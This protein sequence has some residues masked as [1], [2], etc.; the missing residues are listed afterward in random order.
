[1]SR[2]RRAGR[3]AEAGDDVDHAIGQADLLGE[4]AEIDGRQRSIFGR[5]DDH[6]VAG[7]QGRRDT[8]TNQQEG[9]VPRKNEAARP[10]GLTHGPGFVTFNCQRV[11]PAYVLGHVGIISHRRHEVCHVA[12]RLG[13]DLARVE[14]FD[15]SNDVEPP[16]HFIGQPMQERAPFVG[17]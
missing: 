7:C 3:F 4:A 9:K 8:P 1:V 2:H 11:A 14:R 5:L 16:L 6:R 10:P 15:L 17:W 12:L 13:F